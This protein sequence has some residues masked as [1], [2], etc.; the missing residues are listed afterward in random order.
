MD[1]RA[2][3]VKYNNYYIH[4]GL[5]LASPDNRQNISL[6]RQEEKAFI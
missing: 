4:L 3:T 5:E 6:A 1:K 2:T